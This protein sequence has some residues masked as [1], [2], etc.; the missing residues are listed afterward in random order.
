MSS[1]AAPSPAG[2]WIT[3]A[4]FC[5]RF[6][7]WRSLKKGSGVVWLACSGLSREVM[8]KRLPTP[9]SGSGHD[10]IPAGV[11]GLMEILISQANEVGGSERIVAV[12]NGHAGADGDIECLT[13]E[14]E[15]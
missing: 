13:F 15:G 3:A 6:C 9:F 4:G 12:G 2:W 11:L 10:P 1:P 5:H 8:T 14:V 7:E